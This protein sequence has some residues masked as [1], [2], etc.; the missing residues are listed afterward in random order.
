MP[1]GSKNYFVYELAKL[2][3]F[4]GCIIF[5]VLLEKSTFVNVYYILMDRDNIVKCRKE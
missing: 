2:I 4:C 1:F 5:D 3:T